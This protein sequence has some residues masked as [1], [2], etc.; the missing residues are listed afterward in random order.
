MSL[1]DITGNI[2]NHGYK[3]LE[4]ELALTGH[5]EDEHDNAE[6]DEI[7]RISQLKDV[8]LHDKKCMLVNYEIEQMGMGKYQRYLWLL[9]GLGY[10]LGD[11]S[12][13]TITV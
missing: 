5:A 6:N 10:F 2:L 11:F 7:R 13:F 8:G 9:C 1:F 3:P 12:T 4:H